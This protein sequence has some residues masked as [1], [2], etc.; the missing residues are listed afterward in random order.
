LIGLGNNLP[1]VTPTIGNTRVYHAL[2][3]RYDGATMTVYRDGNQVSANAFKTTGPWTLASVG[4]WYSTYYMV[5]DLAE[6]VIFDRALS[7]SERGYVNAYLRAKY[8]LP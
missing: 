7:D 2:S 8:H 1:Q 5:G 6:V 4:S 3:T